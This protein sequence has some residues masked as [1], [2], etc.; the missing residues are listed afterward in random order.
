MSVLFHQNVVV[1][2]L[3]SGSRGNCTYVG[4]GRTGVLVD[5]GLSTRQ[6]LA[7]ME[8]LGLAGMP[9]DA[10]CV[11][12]EHAD[13]VAAA[14]ILDRRLS[15]DLERPLPFYMT[16]GTRRRVHPN[17]LPRR[18]EI[19]RGGLHLRIGRLTIEPVS[20]PH[21]TPEPVSFTVQVGPTRVGVI[22]DL[23]RVTRLVEHQ[24]SSLDVAVVE[25]N[26]DPVM[27]IEGS[28][29]WQL[30]QRIR[31]GHGHLSNEQAA[32][33]VV[34]GASDRLKHVVLAHLS[35]ENNSPD[36]ALRA[37]HMAVHRSGKRFSVHL[38]EQDTPKKIAVDAPLY[39]SP[40]PRPAPRPRSA[41]RARPP[42][43]QESAQGLLFAK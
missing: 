8:Q 37:A 24:L 18:I 25:F 5:C 32:E 15:K 38:G 42:V 11:T 28:Y 13:H 1:A 17:C 16:A 39:T 41:P 23:G 43:V 30:K 9:I 40:A 33:L 31:G 6:V 7:R 14:A 20:V 22:T 21:D 12:H 29:P 4:D 34:K 26:H 27:L 10:V 36:K 3:G 2:V 35:E 19:V